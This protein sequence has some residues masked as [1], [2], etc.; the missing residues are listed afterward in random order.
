MINYYTIKFFNIFQVFNLSKCV[1]YIMVELRTINVYNKKNYIN[2]YILLF[3][4]KFVRKMNLILWHEK[5]E[6][7]FKNK[8]QNKIKYNVF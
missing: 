3:N 1:E 4:V 2:S 7:Y 5:D 8:W 6:I